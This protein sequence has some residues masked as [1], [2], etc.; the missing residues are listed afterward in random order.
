[1]AKKGIVLKKFVLN[2]K[3]VSELFSSSE[4]GNFLKRVGQDIAISTGH[5]QDY[6]AT[7][8]DLTH[9]AIGVVK[10]QDGNYKAW[11]HELKH[12]DLL[13]A[14][15]STGLPTAKEQV[16]KSIPDVLQEEL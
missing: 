11:H 1:M 13:K 9:T 7:A 4:M 15:S 10:V 6:E 14:L 16:E 12:N 2:K 5:P 8:V 3:G